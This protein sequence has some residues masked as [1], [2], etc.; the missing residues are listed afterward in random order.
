MPKPPPIRNRKPGRKQGFTF[1]RPR[2]DKSLRVTAAHKARA[3]QVATPCHS[4]DDM[5]RLALELGLKQLEAQHGAALE[6]AAQNP[7]GGPA[8]MFEAIAERLRA[9]EPYAEVLADYGIEFR[10]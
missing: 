5:L 9:G 6:Y 2:C 8:R 1:G 7:L 10:P 3:A 4:A